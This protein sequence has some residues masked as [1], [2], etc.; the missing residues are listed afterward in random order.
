[1]HARLRGK[2]P[3]GREAEEEMTT[4]FAFW[5]CA[6]GAAL[7]GDTTA[8]GVLGQPDF[9]SNAP[10]EPGG[11]PTSDNQF[12]LFAPAVAISPTGR[13]YVADDGNHRVLSWPSAAS[14][15]NGESAD[16]VLG[17]G[18]FITG[19]PNA[20]G[21]AAAD[22]FF[23]PQGLAVE[24][25]GDL[26][27]TDAFNHRVL[28]F[29]D[30]ANSDGLA[31]LVLGQPDFASADQNL[32]LGEAAASADSLN[33]PGRVLIASGGIYVADSGNSRVLF[34]A[35]P[36]QNQAAAAKVFGQFGDFTNPIKNNDGSGLCVNIAED[37][38]GPPSAENLFNPIGIALDNAGALYVAD[39][40]NNRVLRYDAA[41]SSDTVADVV[42]G[43]ADF[44]TGDANQGGLQFGLQLP[45]DVA[46]DRFGRVFIADSNN[47]RVVV[48][49]LVPT[50]EPVPPPIAVFG[51]LGD[52]LLNDI[53]HGLG[54]S[55]AD[56]DSLSG[57]SGIALDS[58]GA[59]FIVD[60][61][62]SRTL[63]FDVPLAVPVPADIDFDDDVDE[64]DVQAWTGCMTGPAGGI[65][66]T[67]CLPADTNG[68][69][70][71]DLADAAQLM[72][73]YS[74]ADQFPGA[75]CP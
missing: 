18:D 6:L 30:P 3:A 57:P 59:L 64:L 17:Q 36:L 41:A 9:V 68:D 55:L 16:L 50:S 39:W 54:P 27:V 62:N 73:C 26:W 11:T 28:K 52:F 29:D 75:G 65:S 51:Q 74:G 40:V 37:P 71:V 1:L 21:A 15:M 35:E 8:D 19:D 33:Y 20:G 10:N 46:V 44:A 12:F 58:A 25:D 61:A 49:P 22:S 7:P 13:L 14:F 2:E 5:L 67:P 70:D 69:V 34:F 31:D 72:R 53:N 32:G 60:A 63:R 24:S 47:H 38:C 56:A 66:T 45:S 23:L 4:W 43:Q 48:Y 42:Y